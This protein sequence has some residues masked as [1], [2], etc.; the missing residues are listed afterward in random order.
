MTKTTK[1]NNI[2]TRGY[3][4]MRFHFREDGYFNM[5]KAAKEFNKDV[6]EFWLNQST[7]DYVEALGKT[8]GLSPEF[9]KQAAM[10]RN[11]GTWGHPKLAVFFSRWLNTAFS[12]WCDAVIEDILS[13]A[14][15]LEITKPEVSQ[16]IKVEQSP[17]KDELMDMMGATSQFMQ[18]AFAKFQQMDKRMAQLEEDVL[19][20]NNLLTAEEFLIQFDIKIVGT[21]K[22]RQGIKNIIADKMKN[23]GF[24]I[25]KKLSGYYKGDVNQGEKAGALGY[26]WG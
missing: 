19:F 7:D 22:A 4:G 17:V 13:G 5:T 14:A 11:G 24:P 6:K 25:R 21:T 18:G 20:S 16:V 12:V 2:I 9:I 8:L 26:A 23:E 10:G 15:N 1:T 3:E